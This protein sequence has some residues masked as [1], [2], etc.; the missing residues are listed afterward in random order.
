V[1]DWEDVHRR[2]ERDRAALDRALDPPPER[3]RQVFRRRAELLARAGNEPAAASGSTALLIFRLG[4]ER[5]AVELDRVAEVVPHP[6]VS[7]VPG[8]PSQVA[9][10]V[11]VRGE[12]RP[13][14]DLAGLLELPGLDGPCAVLLL[15]RGARE[16]GLR[17]GPVEEIRS[18]P[19]AALRPGPGGSP[20][21]KW[22]T[23]ELV[24]VL[25][26]TAIW[27]QEMVS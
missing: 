24:A 4:A 21:V 2:L 17:T 19:A 3:V 16:F 7:P 10:V 15:R 20:Y 23:P 22:V 13:V 8:A 14:C 12:I 11:Q 18:L 9:G 6:R 5:W 25:D 27:K 1:I 26:T